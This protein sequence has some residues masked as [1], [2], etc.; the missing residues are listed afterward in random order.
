MIIFSLRQLQAHDQV[1]GKNEW[2]TPKIISEK[3]TKK[4]K[5]C[6]SGKMKSIVRACRE[7]TN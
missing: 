7:N 5:L 3:E 2:E 6:D 1:N 4:E